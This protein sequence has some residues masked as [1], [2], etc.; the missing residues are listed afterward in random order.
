MSNLAPPRF[1]QLRESS[2]PY[3]SL[4]QEFFDSDKVKRLGRLHFVPRHE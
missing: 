2:T 3:T 4:Q 1:F